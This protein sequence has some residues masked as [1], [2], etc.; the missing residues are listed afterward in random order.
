MIPAKV[1]N[2]RMTKLPTRESANTEEVYY[3]VVRQTDSNGVP[4]WCLFRLTISG[5]NMNKELL[6]GPD[7]KSVVDGKLLS[8]IARDGEK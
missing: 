8:N 3:R 1:Y 6:H 7:I 4:G 5:T 2:K